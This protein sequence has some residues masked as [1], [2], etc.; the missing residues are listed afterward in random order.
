VSSVLVLA[1]AAG[2]GLLLSRATLRP[3]DQITRAARAIGQAQRLDRRLPLP[4]RSDEVGRLAGT[5]NDMLDRLEAVFLA[6][7]RFVAD[8]SHELRTPLT[9]IRGNVEFIR[10]D[11]SLPAAVRDDALADVS[12]AAGR[13]ARLVNGLLSLARADAGRHLDREPVALRP[14]LES[15]FHEAQALARAT[16]ITVVLG[17]SRLE[18]GARLS[19][20]PDRLRELLMVLIE[21]AV[22]YNHPDGQVQLSARTDGRKHRVSVADTGRGIETED[23]S[24]IFE[25][26]YR[27][28]RTR[29]DDGSGL[30]LAIANWIADEH[31]A[32]ISVESVPDVG[33]TFVVSFPALE[34]AP[35]VMVS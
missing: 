7:R 25:R 27:S 3:I 18:P 1:I 5:F 22:K 29:S 24:H 12:D 21:N 26:F 32:E 9:T 4:A 10:R 28:P 34:P 33:T 35:L 16:N 8:A 17:L 6:Q 23:L 30:G 2:G 13:M 11:P 19:A 15:C 20:D 31:Q 14:V